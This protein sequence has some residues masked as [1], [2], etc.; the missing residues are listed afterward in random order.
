M[1]DPFDDDYQAK[2]QQRDEAIQRVAAF[3]AQQAAIAQQRQAQ[4]QQY[5]Q[6]VTTAVQQAQQEYTGR[7]QKLNI[8]PE[9]VQANAALVGNSGLGLE[10]QLS[11]LID[12]HGPL[13]TKHLA[14]NPDDLEQL[15]RMGPYQAG[16]KLAEIKA[17]S[18]ASINKPRKTPPD[19]VETLRGGG[20]KPDDGPDGAIYE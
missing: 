15:S 5:H 4:Q 3:D 8:S 18:I 16:M 13:I 10:A 7:A 12:D 6:Q 11:I 9:E 20:A 19:P 14:N 2:V 17:K 1:P